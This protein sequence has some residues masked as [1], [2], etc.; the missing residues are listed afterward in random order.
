MASDNKNMRSKR[1]L[2]LP[3]KMLVILSV[4]LLLCAF[5]L[6]VAVFA[7]ARGSYTSEAQRLCATMTEHRFLF[8]GMYFTSA[9]I[10]ASSFY[11]PVREAETTVT[12]GELPVGA[13]ES[14]EYSGNGWKGKAFVFS[15]GSVAP[16]LAS[17]SEG[18]DAATA[19]AG[20]SAGLD[21]IFRD[22]CVTYA[23]EGGN[24][25]YPVVAC[26]PD[27]TLH[28]GGKTVSEIANSGYE[29]AVSADRI[30][31]SGGVPQTGLGGGYAARAAIGRTADGSIVLFCASSE[32]IYPCG[33][34]YEELTSVMY[35][36]GCTEAAALKT[37][38]GLTFGGSYAVKTSG[39]AAYTILLS[40]REA[41]ND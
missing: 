3:L 12:V 36:L 29:W 9:E 16:V 37:A 26:D 19:A 30:L 23:G 4:T 11:R 13:P 28:F 40:G 33:I 27:G 41:A 20:L 17:G 24:E 1:R 15:A 7:L 18:K 8:T 39:R 31:I 10:K 22:G 2:S 5:A 6:S 32:K 21:I 38:G 25:L 14:G 35:G 34:T